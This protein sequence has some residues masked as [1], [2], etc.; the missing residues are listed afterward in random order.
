MELIFGGLALGAIYTLVALGVILVFRATSV[1]NFAQGEILMLGAYAYVFTFGAT[2]NPLVQVAVA[3]LVGAAAGLVCF[4]VTHFLL[5]GASPIVLVIGTLSLLVFAQSTAR[6]LWTDN[7][8]RAEPWIFGDRDVHLAAAAISVNS[9]TCLVVTAAAAGGL[10]LWLEMTSYGR[11][12]RAVAEDQWRA[13][14][15]G[16]HVRRMLAI[17]WGIGGALAALGGVM[18]SPVTG[19][20]PTMGAQIIFPAFIAA[21]LGGFTNLGGAV[22]GGLLLGLVQTYAVVYVGGAF[23]DAVTFGLLLVLLLLRPD[24]LFRSARLRTV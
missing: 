22:V 11:S 10:I 3:I 1:V 2:G 16:I 9:L 18:L 23:R 8:R 17:S 13:A 20:F 19:V 4:F 14:L 24:G 15:S 6:L 12:V 7:P 21:I 5:R